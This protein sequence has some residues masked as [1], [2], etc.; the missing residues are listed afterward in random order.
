[1]AFHMIS[2]VRALCPDVKILRVIATNCTNFKLAD[3]NFPG[4]LLAN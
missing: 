1:M 3:T 4:A 2:A